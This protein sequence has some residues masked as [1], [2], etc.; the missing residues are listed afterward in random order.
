MQCY[1]F[2]HSRRVVS[3]NNLQAMCRR[4][5]GVCHYFTADLGRWRG[6]RAVRVTYSNPDEYGN[7]RPY[8]AYLPA[9]KDDAGCID[10]CLTFLHVENGSG[11]RGE[12]WQAFE[13]LFDCPGLFP[14]GI[15][16]ED[17]VG[18]ASVDDIAL[19]GRAW[20]SSNRVAMVVSENKHKGLPI[21]VNQPCYCKG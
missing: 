9:W 7:S 10:V 18:W 20:L 3:I 12:G 8:S 19:E 21:M 15:A 6:Q 5:S 4:I 14:H 2:D 11:W 16:S 13:Q 17:G 1:S